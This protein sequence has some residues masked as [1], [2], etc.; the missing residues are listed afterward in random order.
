MRPVH[1][2]Y[3]WLTAFEP[4][5]PPGQLWP[6]RRRALASCTTLVRVFYVGLLFC[7]IE[8]CPS[9]VDWLQTPALEPLWPIA[10]FEWTGIRTGVI[11]VLALSFGGAIL[12]AAAP[13]IRLFRV[14]AAA[15][16]LVFSAFFNSFGMINHG[17]HGW[18]WVAIVL[19][20][21][22][23]G[24]I[25]HIAASTCRQQ[26]YFRVVWAAQAAMMLFYSLSGAFKLAGIVYQT[27]RGEITGLNPEAL[28]RQA[29][30]KMLETDFQGPGGYVSI[31]LAEHIWIAWPIF[32]FTL[33][34][35]AFT[36]VVA[37]RPG[38]QRVWGILLVLCHIGIYFAMT[39]MFSWHALLAGLL[40]AC[41]PWARGS[42]IR[43]VV[44]SLPVVG[45]IIA[46]AQRRWVLGASDDEAPT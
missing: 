19:V 28:P 17:W 31:F 20:L 32:L 5:A 3:R 14:L 27:F 1:I 25:S 35:E 26:R 8:C 10:W 40:V 24:D 45:D 15:G 7:Q 37:F 13:T 21:L 30:N 38:A 11:I 46:L 43:S 29:I 2:A 18:L 6:M 39:I 12:A 16:L 44:R 9:W 36:V 42:G 34:L 33:Y 23:D 4:W 41:S 22:P